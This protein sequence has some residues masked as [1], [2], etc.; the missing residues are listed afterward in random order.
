MKQHSVGIDFG[1]S[2]TLIAVSDDSGDARIIPIGQTTPWMP[3]VAALDSTG[4][5]VVGEAALAVDPRRQIRSI[6][7][8]V[9]QGDTAVEVDG[10]HLDARSVMIAIL[11]EALRRAEAAMPG[12]IRNLRQ[13]Y[14]GCPALWNGAQRRLLADVAHELGLPVDVADIIDEPVEIGRAHV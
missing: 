9:T 6:K 13:V 4:A 14:L 12:A 5:L 1:T 7:A 3:S 2:T 8:R 10:V 11:G